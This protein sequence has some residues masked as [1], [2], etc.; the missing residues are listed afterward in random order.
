MGTVILNCLPFFFSLDCYVVR[1]FLLIF[2]FGLVFRLFGGIERWR[3]FFG[4]KVAR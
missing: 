2:A 4:R 3:W 1:V